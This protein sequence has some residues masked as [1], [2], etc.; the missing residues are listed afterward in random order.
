M[1]NPP[2]SLM[3]PASKSKSAR[4]PRSREAQA[5]WYVAPGRAELRPEAVPPPLEGEVLVEARYSALS[6]GTERLVS[7]GLVD[8]GDY[9]RMRAPF[10]AGAFPFPVKYGYSASGVILEGPPDLTGREVFVLHPHQSRFV[11]PASAAH[12]LPEGVGLRRAVLAANLET[13]LNALWDS[14]A[15]PCDRIAIVGGGVVGLLTAYLAARL[16][17]AE[18]T[19][20]DVD[21][22]RAPLAR[23]LGARF[24]LPGETPSA[25]DVVFHTSATEAGLATALAA[26]GREARVVEMSW[27][28]AQ[29]PAVPLGLAFHSQRLAIVASQVGEVAP[30]RRPRWTR[31]K[32]LA[33]ALRLLTD[34]RLDMLLGPDI[35]LATLPGRLQEIFAPSHAGLAPVIAYS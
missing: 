29:R 6:R 13:A 24:A 11:V 17:G 25:A 3:P 19:V 1:F 7:D 8:P 10:Q 4:S 34:P 21:P 23:A 26:C 27:Y 9:E 5:L 32:R 20:V 28:G 18:V 2:S 16:P 31:E 14:G 30:S 15:G 35:P 22:G 33:A 12:P